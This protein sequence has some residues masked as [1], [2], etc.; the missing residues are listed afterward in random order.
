[1]LSYS[2]L[3][4]LRT[5]AR[6]FVATR[7]RKQSAASSP[8]TILISARFQNVLR[9]I[10]IEN[11]PVNVSATF[12]WTLNSCG[13]AQNPKGQALVKTKGGVGRLSA[14]AS[15]L[16]K[17]ARERL[18]IFAVGIAEWRFKAALLRPHQ[19]SCHQPNHVGGVNL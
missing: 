16:S 18:L 4:F 10:R 13:I 5:T 3:S 17:P 9:T 1:M 2:P 12:P 8:P 19:G 14:S 6:A 15:R 7:Y 11:V